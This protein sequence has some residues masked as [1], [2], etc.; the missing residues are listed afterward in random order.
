MNLGL[1]PVQDQPEDLSVQKDP[2]G[3]SPAHR[4]QGSPPDSLESPTNESAR[5]KRV[6]PIP[7]PLDLNVRTF[8]PPRTQGNV[9]LPR[10]PADLPRECLPIRKRALVTIK[11]ELSDQPSPDHHP[12]LPG[13]FLSSS[14][15]VP[16]P[17]VPPN[18]STT[19]SLTP[20]S[21]SPSH[22]AFTHF[23]LL[24]PLISVSGHTSP[25]PKS[26]FL[27]SS[28]GFPTTAS[29]LISP[30]HAWPSP[31][32]LTK[33]GLSP[34]FSPLPHSPLPFASNTLSPA[35]SYHSS[36]S[37]GSREDIPTS[38][39]SQTLLAAPQ[40]RYGILPHQPSLAESRERVSSS[41]PTPSSPLHSPSIWSHSWPTPVWQ[42]FVSG[43]LVRF[44]LPS[45][46]TPWQKSE[47][48]GWK[49]KIAMKVDSRN[50]YHYAPFGLTVVK[51]DVITRE[52]GQE[53]EIGGPS[54]VTTLLQLRMSPHNVPDHTRVE[55]LAKCPLDHPFFVKDKGWCSAHPSLS[56]GKYGIPC[57]ELSLGDVCLPPNHP[58]AVR[59]PDL[60]DRFKRFEFTSQELAEQFSPTVPHPSDS[61]LRHSI[62]NLL[63]SR[64]QAMGA[65]MSPPMSPAGKKP[66]DP[67]KPKRPMNGFMLFAKKFRLEL[68]Q[69]HPGKDN[70][71]ISVLLGEAW[72][73]LPPEERDLYSQKAKAMAEEQKKLYPDCWK[74]KRSLASVHHSTAASPIHSFPS[75]SSV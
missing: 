10:S 66:V 65:V 50:P 22:P 24:H 43:V 14:S 51:I 52:S 56:H 4:N 42:C 47:G 2:P 44:L 25:Y 5:P 39:P 21:G 33:M 69:Q 17:L 37:S 71:A 54:E 46:D 61:P 18:L 8:S 3:G 16:G 67:D 13:H 72:K 15:S 32:A 19:V 35:P 58:D 12:T 1:G 30:T 68:I 23:P 74:R 7:P 48:L 36:T 29:D 57:Q 59:T 20:T 38:H 64:S 75:V 34:P 63:P 40:P 70:R 55:M 11:D 62:A 27:T 28:L 6:K 31:S 60:C 53:G 26:P 41:S 49:D 9:A 73:G 45:T